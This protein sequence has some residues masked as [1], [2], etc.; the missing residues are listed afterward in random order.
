[1]RSKDFFTKPSTA[2]GD[3]NLAAKITKAGSKQTYYTICWLADR[4]RRQDAL[5]AYAY[6]RWVDDQLDTDANTQ[7][8][9]RAFLNRQLELLE[10]SYKGEPP[11]STCPEERMLVD[12]VHGDNEKNSG[13]KIYLR[14][15]MAVMSFDVERRGRM[16]SH[17][18]LSQYSQWLSSAVT[19]Y[20]FHFIGHRCPPPNDP[21]R[22]LAVRGAHVTHMLRD[23]VDD[24]ELGY[25]NIPSE[26]LRS[27]QVTL[28]DISAPAFRAWVRERVNLA[29]YY[30]DTGR[31]YIARLKSRRCRL[32]GFA[33]IARF[34]WT[35]RA[36]ER[37][38]YVLRKDYSERKTARAALWMAWRA[39]SSLV[40]FG[41]N[42][43]RATKAVT[44]KDQLEEE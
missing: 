11:K 43:H 31:Q 28:D 33:Y 3:K 5:R 29:H 18:E 36:I 16:I 26:L 30:F 38:Q 22:Y 4:E 34:E 35:L 2:D 17:A 13:L 20:M 6:F 37:D 42:N 7:E 19:E 40:N 27:R 39:L 25:I 14:D 32:A 21:S 24:I 9:K 41:V 15:M 12:L 23:M 10:G 8:V 1:M 44:L